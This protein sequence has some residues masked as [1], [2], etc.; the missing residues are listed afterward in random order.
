MTE[1]IVMIGAGNVATHIARTLVSVGCAPIQVWSRS[2]NSARMLASEIG[3]G[4]VTDI[5]RVV[6]DADI[7]IISVADKALE[8]VIMQLCGC[9]AKGVFVHTAGTMPMQLFEGRAEHYGVLY[10]MQTFSKQKK[11]DFSVVPCFV[12]ASDE[13]A[14]AVVRRLAR[15]LSNRVYELSGDDRRWLHVAAVFACNFT[16]ACCGMAA[17]LLAEH[18]LDFSVMLPLVDETTRKLHTLTPAEAQTGP[19]ARCDRNV[20]DS[21]LAMLKGEGDLQEVYRMMSEMIMKQKKE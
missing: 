13:G 5:D 21:H 14:L 19:A 7:Y 18:G 11:L 8:N 3:C 20:M 2:E 17:R 15:L 1:R 4:A 12:E 6:S 9:H 16:N 10:P